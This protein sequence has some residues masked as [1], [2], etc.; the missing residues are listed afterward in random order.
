MDALIGL[1]M[2]IQQAQKNLDELK[3]QEVKLEITLAEL[4]IE[5]SDVHRHIGP[6]LLLQAHGALP[7]IAADAPPPQRPPPPSQC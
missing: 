6:Q 4:P 3:S 1:Y 7:V 2:L 5:L